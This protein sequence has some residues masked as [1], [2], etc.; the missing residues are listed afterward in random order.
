MEYLQWVRHASRAHLPFPTPGSVPFLG[1]D[2][3]A[4]LQPFFPKSAVIFSN[5]SLR[6]S[7]FSSWILLNVFSQYYWKLHLR[8][9]L[10]YTFRY[11]DT[12]NIP[13]NFDR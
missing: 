10:I 6:I 5:F 12:N 2:I 8:D 1:L 13:F 7:L 4:L 11:M 3:L 9:A